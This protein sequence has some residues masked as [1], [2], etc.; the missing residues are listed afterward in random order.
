MDARAEVTDGRLVGEPYAAVVYRG[1]R[2]EPVVMLHA[3]FFLTLLKRAS[4]GQEQETS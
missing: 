2:R 3:A 4:F 1:P